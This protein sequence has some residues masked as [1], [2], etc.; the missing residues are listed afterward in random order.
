MYNVIV[1]DDEKTARE[2][3]LNLIQKREPDLQVI[4]ETENGSKALE[5]ISSTHPDILIT[6]ICMPGINGLQLC[7]E[8]HNLD[9]DIQMI[10]LSG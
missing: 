4:A 3:L 10:L 6:D 1:A 8:A 7:Q 2:L 5:A 9:H